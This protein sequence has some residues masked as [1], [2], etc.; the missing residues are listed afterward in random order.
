MM[1]LIEDLIE[2]SIIKRSY[3][4]AV[5]KTNSSF[6]INSMAFDK[7]NLV[8]D[9]YLHRVYEIYE[10]L[11]AKEAGLT[12]SNFLSFLALRIPLLLQ[13]V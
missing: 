11:Q 13:I 3:S 6:T 7:N 1:E 2:S 9:K 5:G 12:M 8:Y 4:G 10:S